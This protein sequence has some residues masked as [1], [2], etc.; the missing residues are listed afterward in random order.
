[1]LEVFTESLGTCL[2]DFNSWSNHLVIHSTNI[3]S[4]ST[5][6]LTVRS[7]RDTAV[8]KTDQTF[9]LCGTSGLGILVGTLLSP[10][11][12]YCIKNVGLSGKNCYY[13]A[14]YEQKLLPVSSHDLPM[15]TSIGT[16]KCDPSYSKQRVKVVGEP[17]YLS[18]NLQV[19]EKKRGK[20]G[21]K[22]EKN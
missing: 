7:A 9:C 6:C 2:T 20:C 14:A 8:N 15:A 13:F 22:L 18:D 21:G 1:M 19:Q 17:F 10:S 11:K 5:T 16:Q 4:V 3:Y 12:I